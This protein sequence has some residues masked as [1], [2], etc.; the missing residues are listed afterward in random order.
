MNMKI[1]FTILL[2]A[3]SSIQSWSETSPKD[4]KGKAV[5]SYAL[6]S[7]LDWEQVTREELGAEM[8]VFTLGDDKLIR[9]T[10]NQAGNDQMWSQFVSMD[11]EKIYKELVAGKKVIH[12]LM[13]YKNWNADKSI[14][15]KSDK[16][17]IFEITG[18]FIENSIKNFFIEKYY[19]TPYGIILTSL[20][21]TERAD[22]KLAKKAQAEFN[23]ITFKS[24]LR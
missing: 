3:C 2:V 7:K 9:L 1:L 20:D 24:E 16:E 18:S 19:I 10:S 4:S 8:Q 13:G 15:K 6:P 12:N 5:L 11:K 17:I 22:S 23:L 21:W 14:E